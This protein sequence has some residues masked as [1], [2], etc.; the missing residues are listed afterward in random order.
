[1][2]SCVFL[3][4]FSILLT[5]ILADNEQL[6]CTASTPL[7]K[8]RLL[9]HHDEVEHEHD[10][11]TSL[12]PQHDYY[13]VH[14]HNLGRRRKLI[15]YEGGAAQTF[16]FE[17]NKKE[18]VKMMFSCEPNGFKASIYFNKRP[19]SSDTMNVYRAGFNASDITT[20]QNSKIGPDEIIVQLEGA[21]MQSKVARCTDMCN[22]YEAAFQ[23][24]NPGN[25][26]LKIVRLRSEWAAI[27]DTPKFPMI[28]YEVFLD[29]LLPEPLEVY[30]PQF[31]GVGNGFWVTTDPK[32]RIA[33]WPVNI[34]DQCSEK[35]KRGVSVTSNI[36]VSNNFAEDTCANEIDA[37]RW[38]R[39]V[40]N[41][42]YHADRD[43]AGETVDPL[44]TTGL[45]DMRIVD[46]DY[47]R[48]KILFIG[49]LHMRDIA[50]LFLDDVCRY[51]H[52]GNL[53][54]HKDGKPIIVDGVTMPFYE[55]KFTKEMNNAYKGDKPGC[56]SI[57]KDE[58][59]QL[60]DVACTDLTVQFLEAKYCE[61]GVVNKFD[62]VDYIVMNCGHFPAQSA[63]YSFGQFRDT[64]QKLMG[65][66]VESQVLEPKVGLP[67]PTTIFWVENTAQPLRQDDYIISHDDW[68]T[69]HRLVLYD[70]I[71]AEEAKKIWPPPQVHWN[72]VPAFHSSLAVYDKLCNCGHYADSAMIPQLMSVVDVLRDT[73]LKKMR[74]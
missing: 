5:S 25:Y 39:K 49:D 15:A 21:S 57:S 60:F 41:R 51:K 61:K 50:T 44:N 62:G 70:A 22:N 26:R 4:I 19:C 37:Y 20:F 46:S 69:Y 28:D 24:V 71:V 31:C 10:A 59:C 6:I 55:I 14:D 18:R 73:M 54:L 3:C 56:T 72:V 36:L 63:H 13:N 42:D 29:T 2:C 17:T 30:N 53:K 43:Y 32:Y 9:A 12:N 35:Q 40:C 48:R 64:I 58:N 23:I 52:D 11:V 68:R 1:M 65:K 8:R 67:V 7:N 47:L 27:K 45:A 34:R 16:T 38:N 66:I 33:D 74:R